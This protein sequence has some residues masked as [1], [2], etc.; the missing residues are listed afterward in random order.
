MYVYVYI[1]IY[2][3]VHIYIYVPC[4]YLIGGFNTFFFPVRTDMLRRVASRRTVRHADMRMAFGV[5]RWRVVLPVGAA[6]QG[7]K[8][9]HSWMFFFFMENPIYTWMIR[10]F[11]HFRKPPSGS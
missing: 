2:T 4:P 10:V 5:D 3:Y 6:S 11:P 7:L 8:V 1:Y 9:V